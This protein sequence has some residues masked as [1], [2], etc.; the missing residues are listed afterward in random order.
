MNESHNYWKTFFPNVLICCS[1]I[2][3]S[4]DICIL[5]FF[6][7]KKHDFVR[8]IFFFKTFQEM[9]T[10]SLFSSSKKVF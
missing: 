4:L 2:T 7:K 6:F 5:K 3:S 10:K 1:S 8:L 9:G